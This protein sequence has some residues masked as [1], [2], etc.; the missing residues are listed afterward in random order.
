MNNTLG[1]YLHIP[2]CLRKCGY[3]D[4]YSVTD[5]TRADAFVDSLCAQIRGAAQIAKEP[6]D[7]VFFGGGTPSLLSVKQLERVFCA[8]TAFSIAPD[9]EISM[10]VNPATAN[11]AAFRA[12][13]ALGVNRLSIGMQSASDRELKWLSRV[14]SAADTVKTVRE[15]TRAGFDNFNLD[16]IYG[17]KEQ[18]ARDFEASV[19]AA[20][21]L[22]PTHLSLYALTLSETV[23]LYAERARLSPDEVQ[24]TQYLRACER[25]REAGMAQYE[26]SNFAS[27]GFACAHNLKYW[28]RAPYLGFG[29]GASSFY[30][31]R[32]FEIAPDLD[33]YCGK[34]P[35][36]EELLERAPALSETDALTEELILALRLTRGIDARAYAGK[37]KDGRRFLSEL[38]GLIPAG[39]AAETDGRVRLTQNGFLVSNEIL[40]RL[41]C[42]AGL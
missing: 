41:L 2:F 25:L 22:C 7:T 19:C 8:L 24:E 17:L 13:R 10:E 40:A 6:V 20:L 27:P 3:C 35:G 1:L 42:A 32:R 39:F 15:L 18:T 29:P 33:A 5:R 11:E 16:L 38:D 26:I 34:P 4:F 30:S 31:G 23:P 21:E 14:H 9:A 36:L 37:L 12:Y 28:T